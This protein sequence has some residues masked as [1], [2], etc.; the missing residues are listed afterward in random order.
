MNKEVDIRVRID[1]KL[2]G[3]YTS[4]CKKNRFVLSKRIRVLMEMDMKRKMNNYMEE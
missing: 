1:K 4:F 3:K 2:K